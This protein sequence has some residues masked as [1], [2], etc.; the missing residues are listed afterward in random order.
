[1]RWPVDSSKPLGVGCTLVCQFGIRQWGLSGMGSLL[2]SS[3]HLK[4]KLGY[5]VTLE[6]KGSAR[7]EGWGAIW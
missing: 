7:V 1:M 5:L 4:G 2:E 3:A 6:V